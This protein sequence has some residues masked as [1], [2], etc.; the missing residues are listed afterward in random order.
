MELF[1]TY[2]PVALLCAVIS[3]ALARPKNRVIDGILLGLF[4]GPIGIIGALLVSG[5][6]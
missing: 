4:L 3:G 2:L 6:I 1:C 5:L